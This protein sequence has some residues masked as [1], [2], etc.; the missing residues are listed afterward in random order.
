MSVAPDQIYSVIK[1]MLVRD[2]PEFL[3]FLIEPGFGS[4]IVHWSDEGYDDFEGAV[5]IGMEK[6]R[7]LAVSLGGYFIIERASANI[8]NR[9][10][11]WGTV[12]DSIEIMRRMKQQYDP[13]YIFNVGRFVGG[14]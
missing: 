11:P 7:D 10:D 13:A 4:I 12:G 1:S 8:K 14:I 6:A 5:I 2:K 9:L 3:S